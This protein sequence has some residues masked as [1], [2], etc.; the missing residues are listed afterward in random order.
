LFKEVNSSNIVV[1]D[2][3]LAD[4][5]TPDTL[6]YDRV[7]SKTYMA[8]EIYEE[9]GY[10]KSIDIYSLG[11]ILYILLCG[12]PPFEPEEGITE[13]EFPSSEWNMISNSVKNLIIELLN[14]N[15]KDRPTHKELINHEWVKGEVTNKVLLLGTIKTIKLFNTARRSGRT[16][17]KKDLLTK[18]SIFNIFDTITNNNTNNQTNTS[19]N[20]SI[21]S[22]NNVEDNNLSFDNE[23]IILEKE[24]YKTLQDKYNELSNDY[25]ALKEI[26]VEYKIKLKV[27]ED[28]LGTLIQE[29]STL[30]LENEHIK[31]QL[32]HSNEKLKEALSSIHTLDI[33]NEI[34]TNFQKIKDQLLV[35]YQGE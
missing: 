33:S 27:I 20:T 35:S 8:P 28:K 30:Q 6:L 14:S 18:R 1:A 23:D 15:P 25:E 26:T 9:N 31:I 4:F 32:N 13:L 21:Q 16:M 29:K 10:D 7:G 11:V 5:F 19:T 34:N 3:G 2:F 24:K 22:N 17:R 12:Y